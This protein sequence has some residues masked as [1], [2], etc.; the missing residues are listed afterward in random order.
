MSYIEGYSVH[1]AKH[2]LDALEAA[3]ELVGAVL[4]Q[5]PFPVTITLS[6]S[7]VIAS[8][9]TVPPSLPT[10]SPVLVVPI[11]PLPMPAGICNNVHDLLKGVMCASS[12]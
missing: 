4:V 10:P 1:L 2:F 3:G 11:W 7:I 12:A 5:V 9:T 6:F 8:A